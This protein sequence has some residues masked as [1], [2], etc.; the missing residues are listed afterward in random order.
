MAKEAYYFSH[1]SNAHND[2]KI[3]S[4]ICDYGMAGYGMYW[5]LIENLREQ[6]NY[7]L[8]HDK[9]TW[10]A[11]AMQMQ[12][13]C[14]AVKKYIEDCIYEYALL[15]ISED[16]Y[17]Y[18]R[19]LNRRMNK[20]LESKEKRIAAANKRWNKENNAKDMQSTCNANAMDM[21]SNANK[22]KLNEIKLNEIK[23]IIEDK[24]HTQK[25]T[26]PTIEE[27]KSYC[28]SRNNNVDAEKFYNFY[29]A[30]GWMVG[31]NKMKD[32]QAAVRTWESK[33]SK[34]RK[35]VDF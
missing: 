5:V 35:V 29:Q 32:W 8:K 12:S 19:S 15:D 14:D 7:S 2:T 34:S 28:I 21:Q 22:I 26:P 17:F 31:K 16:M 25:F 30:K 18:S 24:P 23:D 1:D 6:S 13:T 20:Y 33:E 3:L 10:K 11:L 9:Q 27:V 4:M